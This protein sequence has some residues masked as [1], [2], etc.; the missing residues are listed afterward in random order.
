MNGKGY[1]TFRYVELSSRV[2]LHGVYDIW[3]KK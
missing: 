1:N 3:N 2:R